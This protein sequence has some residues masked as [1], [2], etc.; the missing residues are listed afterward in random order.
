[1]PRNETL[2]RVI[3]GVQGNGTVWVDVLRS[4]NERMYRF[5]RLV[6]DEVERTQ[7]DNAELMREW[8][9]APTNVGNLANNVL[10]TWQRQARRRMELA[11]TVVDDLR[12]MTAGTRSIWERVSD[13]SRE[14]MSGTAQA[15][16]EAAGRVAKE[17]SD[18]AED[19]S[20][21]ANNAARDLRKQSRRANASDN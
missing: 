2:D 7:D 13:N 20:E 21:A 18:R 6:I 10:S 8:V 3:N 9:G 16:R 14:A 17:A 4:N 5:N 19:V 15:G 1:M 11:R 12:D